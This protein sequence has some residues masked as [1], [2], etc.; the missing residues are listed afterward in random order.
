MPTPEA[1][2]WAKHKPLHDAVLADARHGREWPFAVGDQVRVRGDWG[3]LVCDLR[4]YTEKHPDAVLRV[5]EVAGG[6]RWLSLR[7]EDGHV[8]RGPAGPQYGPSYFR[9]AEECGGHFPGYRNP[10]W[11]GRQE[12]AYY[13]LRCDVPMP[14]STRA[15]LGEEKPGG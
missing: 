5:H 14:D 8:Y 3:P 6:G 15:L 13:C 12:G 7:D 2:D 10:G 11:P 1:S 9:I 4:I